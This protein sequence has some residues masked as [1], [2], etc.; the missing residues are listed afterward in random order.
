MATTCILQWNCRGLAA[1][2]D[3]LQILIQQHTPAVICLQETMCRQG[4]VNLRQY[5]SFYAPTATDSSHRGGVAVLVKNRV[6]HSLVPLN[7]TLPA[8]AVR[9]TLHRP[10]TICSLYLPPSLNYTLGDLLALVNQLPSP[11]V[12]C[13]DFNAH[14]SLWGVQALDTKGKVVED[15]LV[16]TDLVLLNDKSPTYLHPAT[17][18]QTAIDLTLCDPSLVLDLSWSVCEDSHGSDHFPVIIRT[19][20]PEAERTPQKWKLAKGDWD[21]YAIATSD[22]MKLEDF[23][24]AD[25]PVATFSEALIKIAETCIPKTSGK[26]RKPSKPWFDDACKEQLAERNSALSKLK[27]CVSND[28]ISNFREARAQTRRFIHRRKREMWQQYVSKISKKALGHD[29][30]NQWP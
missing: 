25:D 11:V 9:V 10:I 26:P 19:E 12:F 1:N 28:N 16:D 20:K 7:S 5:Q 3:E 2:L 6:P 30:L 14:S 27:S 17:G 15:L 21:R 13:G 29:R 4:A 22:Q 24:T 8:V 18:T 23:V